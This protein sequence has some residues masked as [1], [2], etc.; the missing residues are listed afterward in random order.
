[1]KKIFSAIAITALSTMALTSCIEETFPQNGAPSLEQVSNA[2]G[3]FDA[4]VQNL[5]SNLSGKRTYN[6]RAYDYGY[7]SFFQM[8][9]VE[10]QDI[11]PI[12]NC[13]YLV[14]YSNVQYM[15]SGYAITQYPWTSYYKWITDCN[16]VL[17][18][19][20]A[21]NYAE[22]Q[23]DKKVGVGIAYAVRAMLYLDVVRMYAQKP[24]AVDPKALTTIKADETRTIDQARNMERMNWEESFDFI[25]KDL[26]AAEKHLTGYTRQDN[27][28]PDLS[29]V[30]GLKARTYLEMQNWAKAEE[31]AKKA[32]EGY[33]MMSQEEYLS[34]A[35]GFNSPNSSWMLS[36]KFVSTDPAIKDNDG[37]DSWGSV[38]IPEAGWEGGY[39]SKFGGILCIDRHLFTS[40]PE[41]DFRKLCWVDFKINDM[42]EE[43]QLKALEA[44]SSIEAN[45][46][47]TDQYA[48]KSGPQRILD[49]VASA[50][51]KVGGYSMKFRGVAGLH[52]TKYDFWCVSVPLMRV[53]EMKLIEIEAAGMQDEAR[54]KQLLEAFAKT[55]DPQ[56]QYGTHNDAY[57]N[58]STSD[59][60]NEVWW[61]RRVELWG[62]GFAT[63]DIKRLNKG[64]IR[65]YEGT[66]HTKGQRWNTPEGLPNW[67]V[68]AFV[69]TESNNNSTMTKNPDPVQPKEDAKPYVFSGGVTN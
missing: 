33:T 17:K 66:N 31:Y 25:L 2:P 62:E 13:P 45:P 5:T 60:Q 41:S 1:M 14:W 11:V 27:T 26:D 19:G 8:R 9:D 63:F 36:T 34:H 10:G 64:I 46:A 52:N 47:A 16:L 37:D 28:T 20:G 38:I 40:I 35:N 43:A 44:Y 59:F 57:Y 15:A 65:S 61:Q 56:Y 21:I 54:G 24:Y 23:T 39:H 30:Y 48:K 3:A 53:E 58:N 49:A 4:M 32:Q 7:P 68:W 69:G 50:Q 67:M 55:R 12:G 29:V 22:A 42:E 6:S 18:N 51:A